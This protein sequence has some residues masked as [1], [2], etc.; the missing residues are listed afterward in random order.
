VRVEGELYEFKFVKIA[1]NIARHP[2]ENENVLPE[3]LRRLFG[4]DAGQPG[5]S[6]RVMLEHA[7]DAYVLTPIPAAP[8]P[9]PAQVDS[10][11]PAGS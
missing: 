2:G 3:I 6:H 11:I 8:D 10:D 9:V 5:M 4:P 7:R 1:V